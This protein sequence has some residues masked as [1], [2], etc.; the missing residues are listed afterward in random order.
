MSAVGMC[1]LCDNAC[2]GVC[3]CVTQSPVHRHVYPVMG[4]FPQICGGE[5]GSA[6]GVI[7]N[8]VQKEL[9]KGCMMGHSLLQLI[10][11]TPHSCGLTVVQVTRLF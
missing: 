5:V 7:T 9:E 8:Y 2:G 4:S 10:F 1:T 6:N 3:V 11:R